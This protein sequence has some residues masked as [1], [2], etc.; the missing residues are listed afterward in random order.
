V[1]IGPDQLANGR[2]TLENGDSDVVALVL[3]D[4]VDK[5]GVS[6]IVGNAENNLSAVEVS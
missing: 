3:E 5:R 1:H 4:L 6:G 2:E